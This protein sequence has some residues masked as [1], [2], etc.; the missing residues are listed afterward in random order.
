VTDEA[1]LADL[2]ELEAFITH[3]GAKCWYTTKAK[4]VLSDKDLATLNA[5]LASTRYTNPVIA[6]WLKSKGLN[7]NDPG[8][9]RNRECKC[10]DDGG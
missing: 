9:H 4:V 1:S 3:N 2:S 10:W 5:A 7:V 8:R 6:K